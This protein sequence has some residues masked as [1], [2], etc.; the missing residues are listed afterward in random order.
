MDDT[1][2]VFEANQH[3]EQKE[4]PKALQEPT[5]PKSLLFLILYGVGNMVMGVGNMTV[6]TVL[7]PMQIASLTQSNQTGIF[8]LIL[9][10]GA[11]AAVLTNPLGGMLSDRTTSRLGRRRPW[12]IAGGMLAVVALLLLATTSSLLAI[13]LEWILVQIGTKGS[14]TNNSV[15]YTCGLTV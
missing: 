2:H 3:W 10:I 5:H 14:P 8:S 9:G 13:T 11:V 6:A 15:I 1:M 12:L 4:I 7:L